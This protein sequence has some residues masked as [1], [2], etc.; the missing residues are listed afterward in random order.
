MTNAWGGANPAAT[1][2]PGVDYELGVRY[3]VN[4]DLN[5]T[6]IRVYSAVVSATFNN[7]NAYIRTPSDV[8][9]ATVD[10]PD[11]LAIGWNT[12]NL[13]VP[14]NIGPGTTVWLTYDTITDYVF[15]ANA[16]PQNSSDNAVTA[17]SGG[18]HNNPGNL[19]NNLT[20]TFYGIDFV[21]DVINH[22][23]PTVT[24][25]VTPTD[26]SVSAV[27]AISDDHP[28]TVTYKIDWGDGGVS[29]VG[30]SLGPHL[31]TYG[32]PGLYAPMV[33]ATDADLNVD[34]FATAVNL[35]APVG[36]DASE[37]W[38][39]PILDAVV[40]EAQ[41][42]GYFDKVSTHEPKRKP[43][44]GLEAAI[45]CDRIESVGTAS[46]LSVT[47]ARIVFIM[48]I[49]TNMLSEP[50]DEI[51]PSMMRAVS[52]MIRNLHDDFD[53]GGIIRNVD[54]LGASGQP[55]FA[56]AGY[57]E[58]DGALFRIYDIVIPCIV[59]DVWPQIQ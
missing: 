15:I 38:L 41:R 5:V 29:N 8:I 44:T 58:M 43:G 49:F 32:A 26:L 50:R 25:T 13:A 40:S 3:L 9:L 28:E 34:A 7:R 20:T 24:M 19:P 51:D 46:G 22:F 35:S 2:E 39:Q 14:L 16:F 21:Y 6:A 17:N 31:H 1:S 4:N 23:P 12:V 42:T 55:L 52:N 56:Q 27:I 59:N 45:W 18:F 57:V 48:R 30:T 53:F 10:M 54:L 37:S 47:S 33:T 36:T 11:S